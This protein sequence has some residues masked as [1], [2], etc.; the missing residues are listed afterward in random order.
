MEYEYEDVSVTT[1]YL[2]EEEFCDLKQNSLLLGVLKDTKEKYALASVY[3]DKAIIFINEIE[4][5]L[6]NEKEKKIILAHEIA[7]T[8]GNIVDNEEADVWALESLDDECKKILISQW[9]YRHGHPYKG[10]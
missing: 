1:V 9:Q 2:N 6:L 3:G 8:V 10:G 5:D 7:H 4:F